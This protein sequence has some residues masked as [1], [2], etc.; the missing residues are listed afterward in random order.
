MIFYDRKPLESEIE[1]C[2]E[3]E[4]QKYGIYVEKVFNKDVVVNE[5]LQKWLSCTAK[6]RRIWETKVI[7]GVESAKILREAAEILYSD[8]VI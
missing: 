2:I 8:A 7:S 3:K 4:L 1:F 6:A 5:D